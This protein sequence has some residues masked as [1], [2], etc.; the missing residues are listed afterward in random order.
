[1]GGLHLP[2][3]VERNAR[4]LFR[5]VDAIDKVTAADVKR[6][7]KEVFVPNKRTVAYVESTRTAPKT[8]G[9]AQ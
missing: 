3:V 5:E 7:A 2:A 4:E 6:V 1:M 9:G 8:A